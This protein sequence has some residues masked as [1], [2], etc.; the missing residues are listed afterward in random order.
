M[1]PIAIVVFSAVV[2]V[3]W[4]ETSATVTTGKVV[5]TTGTVDQRAPGVPMSREE[6]IRAHHERIQK[7]IDENRGRQMDQAH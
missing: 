2:S 6:R 1:R 4:P 3:C 5:A 7:I